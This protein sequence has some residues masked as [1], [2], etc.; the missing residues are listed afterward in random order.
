MRQL[1]G[2]LTLTLIQCFA[3]GWERGWIATVFAFR[4]GK[5]QNFGQ[6]SAYFPR[7]I[8]GPPDT[9]ARPDRPSA[10]PRHILSL[11]M[12]GEIIVGFKNRVVVDGP[13][14]DFVIFENAFRT[15]SGKVFVEPAVV[16][17]SRDG[18][19]WTTFPWDSLTLRG[20]AGLTPTNG[21]A[22]DFLDPAQGGGGDWFDLGT[23]HIDTIRYIRISDI[24]G[25]LAAHPEH[26]LW[27]P[28]LSGFD[29]DAVGSRYL[30]VEHSKAAVARQLLL[31]EPCLPSFVL[32][33]SAP[34]PYRLF[35]LEGRQLTAGTFTDVLCLPWRGVF[36]LQLQN[37]CC[38]AFLL[39]R[40]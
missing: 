29:L 10:D 5:G 28:T 6:D 33:I 24:T 31:D 4:P 16:S 30:V 39:L 18:V 9:A 3:Q 19:R 20:C 23:L 13:G 40:P 15:P 35:S 22:L 11:G 14:V 8:F 17:V 26:P 32:G 37:P 27:D 2:L 7:N 25:W 21:A 34:T 36:V 38:E 12:G 1:I